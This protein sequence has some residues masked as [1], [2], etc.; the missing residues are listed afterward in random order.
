[1]TSA[2]TCAI[3]LF[4]RVAARFLGVAAVL[5]GDTRS[6]ADEPQ[7][8]GIERAGR[9][10]DEVAR[11]FANALTFVPRQFID[12]AFRGSELAAILI[13][14]RQLV[15][16]YRDLLSRPNADLLF[17]P[18]LF[19]E[20]GSPVSVGARMVFDSPHLAANQRI[21][22]GGKDQVESESRLI[23]KGHL[24]RLPSILSLETHYLLQ[25]NLQF[26]GVGLVPRS[27]AR[28]HFVQ[29]S[30]HEV[31]YYTEQRTR[32]LASGGVRLSETVELLVSSSLC[33][34]ALSNSVAR[35]ES[36]IHAVFD[37]GSVF[38]SGSPASF[39]SYSEFAARYDSRAVR[40]RPSP[41]LQLEAYFGGARPLGDDG[42]AFVRFGARASGS[43]PV[44]RSHNILAVRLAVDTVVAEKTPSLPFVELVH[45]PEF[46]GF[47][48]RRDMV[49]FLGSL[50]YTWSLVPAL[51]MRLFVDALSVA[52]SLEDI[53]FTQLIK[54]RFAGGVGIDGFAGATPLARLSLSASSDGMR[55][56][57]SFGST[58]NYGDR[59]HRQ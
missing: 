31:G 14:D 18:T 41:G 6:F 43:V 45:F 34:R 22:F 59:Q 50:D 57:A 54:M 13:T 27:D 38:E 24:G 20:T 29:R 26:Y 49:G 17:F 4:S 33:R 23:F 16:R 28:N 55:V 7:T 52:P 56:I 21:G 36:A 42:T 1:M 10:A 19:A 32:A 58:Q 11:S 3:R 35:G 39:V 44:Y 40:T 37:E 15:P 30:A 53:G 25:D 5:L 2:Q 12:Y 51:G 8:R 48:T 9:A 47:D 46:R